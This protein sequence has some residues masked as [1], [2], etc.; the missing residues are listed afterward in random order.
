MSLFDD[1]SKEY[2]MLPY[3]C[4]L[5]TRKIKGYVNLEDRTFWSRDKFTGFPDYREIINTETGE[6]FGI[7][8]FAKLAGFYYCHITTPE[9]I[10]EE[11]QMESS[12]NSN[13]K[14]NDLLQIS[15]KRGD[16]ITYKGSSFTDYMIRDSLFVVINGT[17]WIGMYNMDCVEYV[18][19]IPAEK[20]EQ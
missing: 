1:C 9:N 16:M 7:I 20:I 12:K 19:Y 18:A 10:N 13:S 5:S 2:I 11:K 6:K 4:E 3:K 17:Q 14:D 15:L 8:G